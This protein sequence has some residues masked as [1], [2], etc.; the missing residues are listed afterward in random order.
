VQGP[1]HRP[2][3]YLS[4]KA[5]TRRQVFDHLGEQFRSSGWANSIASRWFPAWLRLQ[6]QLRPVLQV[7]DPVSLVDG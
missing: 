1:P 3:R 4:G 7:E 6:V 5:A 2:G